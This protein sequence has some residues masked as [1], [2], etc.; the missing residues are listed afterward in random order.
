[1]VQVMPNYGVPSGFW[2]EGYAGSQAMPSANTFGGYAPASAPG[3]SPAPSG[4]APGA[5]PFA[6]LIPSGTPSAAAPATAMENFANSA[7][8]QFQLDQ[9]ADMINNRY[10]GLGTLQSGA[11]MKALQDYGQN[12]ALNNY[13]MPYMGLLGGQQSVGAGAASSIAGVGANFGN[14]AANI[15]AGMGA[16]IQSGA[17]SASNSALL[18]GQAN[19][20]MWGSIGG[21]LGTAASS[22]VPR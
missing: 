17:N 11:A 14:T 13:F 2:D 7:G 22:F 19:A 21:A 20:N 3:A 4:S 12:T 5:N 16:N 18:N 10:A 15:N 1:M 8:M 9:G 6:D